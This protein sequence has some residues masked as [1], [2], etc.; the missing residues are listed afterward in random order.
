MKK[1]KTYLAL[2]FVMLTMS[3]CFINE[4]TG[5]ANIVIDQAE[6]SFEN[7]AS[8]VVKGSFC[9][10]N[11]NS[12]DS[13]SIAFKGEIKSNKQRDDIKIRYEK[14]GS[15]LEVWIEKPKSYR[16]S[17]KGMLDF[18]VPSNTNVTVK[19]SSGSVYVAN[20]G[21]S[22]VELSAS[23]GSVKAE[24]IDSNLKV[25]AS[26]GSIKAI[27]ISGNLTSTCSSG[28]QYLSKI[29]G[30]TRA[31]CSSGS[32]KMEDIKGNVTTTCSSG[33]QNIKLI[34]GNV[35]ATASSGSLNISQIKGNVTAKA[36]S[37]S[38]KLRDIEGALKV[39][40]SSGG[41]YGENISLT[42]NSSFKSSSGGIKMGL[43]N[44]TEELS[45]NLTASSG[46]LQAKGTN[47]K[48]KL[49]IDKGVI[50]ITGVSSSGGQ[51]YY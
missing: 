40:T 23:S 27:N 33:S 13:N 6:K 30:E 34:A 4:V 32:I 48:K 42:G 16:G 7:I 24:N 18:K 21:Q 28:S 19:N 50:L 47:G 22:I 45:F 35:K 43:T 36:S 5:Q 49:K 17:F 15:T 9:A 44:A 38:I 20:I 46:G 12:H 8:V 29:G 11:V 25:S 26:S 41:Q 10:V 2:A 1:I 51:K 39:N 3:S 14:N 31:T 37:G